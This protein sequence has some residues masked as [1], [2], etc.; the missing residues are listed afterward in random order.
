MMSKDM[1][2]APDGKSK[3]NTRAVVALSGE[4]QPPSLGQLALQPN[5][6][7]AATIQGYSREYGDLVD[8]A[9]LTAELNKE[10][11]N[12]ARA[13]NDGDLKRSEG[14][15]TIQAH[16]LDAIFNNL[17]QRA[18]PNTWTTLTATCDWG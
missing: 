7:A 6:R 18:R 8:T 10:L 16:T 11:S 2:K 5:I 14:M 12:Q 3:P 15:L 17:A 13:V 1:A 9:K 4:D